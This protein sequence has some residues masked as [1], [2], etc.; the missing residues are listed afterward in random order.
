MN[1]E[2]EKVIAFVFKRS[3]KKQ[4]IYSDFYLTLSMELKWFTPDNAKKFLDYAIKNNFLIDKNERVKP[5][6]DYEKID[7]PYG[8]YPTK[9]VYEKDAKKDKEVPKQEIEEDIF[10][11]L[12]EKI[13]SE[14][15][16]NREEILKEIK[17]LEQEKN[18]TQEIAALLVGKEYNISLEEY[19]NGVEEKIFK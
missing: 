13:E 10:L 7:V 18:I 8:F 17:S 9:V 1:S 16:K 11:K 15:E 14:T 6:F 5:N 2:A 3:G 19:Y 4:I 12:V